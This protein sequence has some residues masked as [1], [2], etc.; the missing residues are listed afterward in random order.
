MDINSIG[1]SAAPTPF[2]TP[3]R[4]GQAPSGAASVVNKAP[5]DT[6]EA[7][8]SSGIAANTPEAVFARRYA[9]G[10][11][12]DRDKDKEQQE[13]SFR[14]RLE[15]SVNDLNEFVLPYNTS[16]QFSIEEESERLVV[17]VI[18]KETKEVIKQV[19]SEEAIELAKALDKL[20]GLLVQQ[21]A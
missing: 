15:E 7:L 10:V 21:E 1:A 5:M 13:P 19:P 3:P 20:K 6:P 11:N 18:D 12:A 2:P 4:A 14:E 17:K 8:P 9:A 16:L